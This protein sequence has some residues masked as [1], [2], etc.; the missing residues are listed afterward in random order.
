MQIPT[1]NFWSPEY[2]PAT[3][4]VPI[5]PLV[6]SPEVIRRLLFDVA[7][8]HL[9]LLMFVSLQI[10]LALRPREAYCILE[11]P[12]GAFPCGLYTEAGFK[13]RI[14][15]AAWAWMGLLPDFD[16]SRGVDFRVFHNDKP[17]SLV[18]LSRRVNE[19]LRAAGYAPPGAMP[20]APLRRS[21]IAAMLACDLPRADIKQELGLRRCPINPGWSED[22]GSEFYSIFP[23]QEEAHE[24]IDFDRCRCWSPED[25]LPDTFAMLTENPME[26]RSQRKPGD[27]F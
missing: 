3:K 27:L 13:I 8:N 15:P 6:P 16:Y 2:H 12:W 18:K 10:W 26:P 1:E 17:V 5:S 22:M 25:T 20:S 19:L 4:L 11:D 7:E 21:K 24:Y 14:V 9:Y 23:S